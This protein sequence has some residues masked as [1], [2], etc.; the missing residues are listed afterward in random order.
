MG[1]EEGIKTRSNKARSHALIGK[2]Y[3]IPTTG[4]MAE[5][6]EHEIGSNGSNDAASGRASEPDSI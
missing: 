1:R 4:P 5:R 3:G 2:M 6:E